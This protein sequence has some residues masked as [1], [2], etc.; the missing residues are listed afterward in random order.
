MDLFSRSAQELNPLIEAGSEAFESLAEEAHD[1]GYVMDTDTLEAFG[2]LDDNMQRLTNTAQ[3]VENSFG[4]VLLPLLTDM[5]DDAVSLMGNFS[6]A[7]SGTEGDIESIGLLCR[8]SQ[9]FHRG[10][11]F[12]DVYISP[13]FLRPLL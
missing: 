7:L 6:A 3:A 2:A 11:G 5:S 4:M 1:V 10:V 8:E 13:A 12:L 9:R